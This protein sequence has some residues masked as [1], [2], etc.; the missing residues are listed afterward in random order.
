MFSH[1]HTHTHTLDL[2]RV[3]GG[4]PFTRGE[5]AASEAITNAASNQRR[6]EDVMAMFD[7]GDGRQFFSMW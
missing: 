4:V 3:S 1:A 5:I 7:S 2:H 6:K